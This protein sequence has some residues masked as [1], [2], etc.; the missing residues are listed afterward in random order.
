M[1]AQALMGNTGDSVP[2]ALAKMTAYRSAM[3]PGLALAKAYTYDVIPL[4]VVEP[5]NYVCA[6]YLTPLH[7]THSI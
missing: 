1:H 4:A 2:P 7:F 6:I 3:G 5:N